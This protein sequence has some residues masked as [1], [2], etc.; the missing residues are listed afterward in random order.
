MQSQ[1]QLAVITHLLDPGGQRTA[2]G[3]PAEHL[4]LEQHAGV[5]AID[6]GLDA[7]RCALTWQGSHFVTG[8]EGRLVG[9][10]EP[11][12]AAGA[13]HAPLVIEHQPHQIDMAHLHRLVLLTAW[14]EQILLHAPVEEGANLVGIDHLEA[15]DVVHHGKR[16]VGGDHRLAVGIQIE[17]DLDAVPFRHPFRQLT[18][19]QQQLAV[20]FASRQPGAPIFELDYGK[21]VHLANL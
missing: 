16:L 10:Q 12:E 4:V 9:A 11:L 7:E 21:G 6:D 17:E 3:H 15:D 8:L 19:G 18:L 20:L 13:H 14:Y 1:I 2:R 5:L